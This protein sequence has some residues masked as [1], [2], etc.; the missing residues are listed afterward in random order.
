MSDSVDTVE[1]FEAPQYTPNIHNT[2]STGSLN[3]S[4]SSG[5]GVVS[6]NDGD[7]ELPIR[8]TPDGED[9]DGALHTRERVFE[10]VS[11]EHRADVESAD[12]IPAPVLTGLAQSDIVGG[13]SLQDQIEYFCS[14]AAGNDTGMS[15][16][17]TIQST[18]I[19]G[20]D[21]AIDITFSAVAGATFYDIYL[22]ADDPPLFIARITEEQRAQGSVITTGGVG[23]GDIAGIQ[24]VKDAGTGRSSADVNANGINVAHKVSVEEFAPIDCTGAAYCDLDIVFTAAPGSEEDPA[25]SIAPFFRNNESDGWFHGETKELDFASPNGY[26]QRIRVDCRGSAALA[27]AITSIAGG[28]VSIHYTLS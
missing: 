6:G 11:A 24:T 2:G 17:S 3:P 4:T 26:S 10:E 16:A 8:A 15:A 7:D 13:G 25:L 22:S 12:S 28:T 21:Q 23:E 20:A 5:G 19:D 14:V 1:K 27:V 9:G 18:V